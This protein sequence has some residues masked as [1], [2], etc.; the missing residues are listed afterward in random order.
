MLEKVGCWSCRKLPEK[1]GRLS[2][3]HL[4]CGLILSLLWIEVF[5]GFVQRRLI[6]FRR[7]LIG[8]LGRVVFWK[9]A[10]KTY[11]SLA[12]VEGPVRECSH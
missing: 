8:I 12:A 9:E 5:L 2:Y 1:A 4:D 3:E 11:L 6:V 7:G 10:Y